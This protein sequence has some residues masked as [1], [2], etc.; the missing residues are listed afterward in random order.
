[1]DRVEQRI[2]VV[3]VSPGDVARERMVAQ[4]VVD[5][6]NRGVAADRGCWLSLWRW[7]TDARPGMHLQGP[8]GLIDELMCLQD[9]D[10]VVGVFWKRFGTPTGAADSGTEHELRRAWAAWREQGRPEVM[11]YFCTRAY[12]PKTPEELAQWQRVLEFQQALPE[13]QLW[14]RYASVA[15]FE[16]LLREHLTVLVLSRVAPGEPRQTR[17]IGG[18]APQPF[19]LPP[20]L[21]AAAQDVIVGR[22]ADLEI[23]ADVYTQAAAGSRQFLLLSGEPGIGKTRLAAEWARRA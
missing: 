9:V 5:E 23:L 7:E 2:R 21:T 22:A 18:V 6:L 12:S 8:Q 17:S 11:V 3:V 15:T 13:Q 1:M 14:W 16:R 20:A 19:P 4:A 10:I